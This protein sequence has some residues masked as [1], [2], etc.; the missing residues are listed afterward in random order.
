MGKEKNKNKIHRLIHKYLAHQG[1]I[2]TMAGVSKVEIGKIYFE[3]RG[4]PII[5]TKN[6][7][8]RVLKYEYHHNPE[9]PIYKYKDESWPAHL[10]KIKKPKPV[11]KPEPKKV[12]K[13]L[14]SGKPLTRY[15]K[16]RKYLKSK[17]WRSFSGRIK[18]QRNHTCE[19]CGV[20]KMGLDLHTHH[21]TYDR[22]FDEL[23][24]DVQILCNMCHK[25]VHGK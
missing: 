25:K 10:K 20:K 14:P 3:H 9:S 23:P 12:K 17:K 15:E 13:E 11:I 19:I 5:E 16:Y 8:D 1:L 6:R 22:L 7:I 21:L 18:A 24:E 4:M 2:N